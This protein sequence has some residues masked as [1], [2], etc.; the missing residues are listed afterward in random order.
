MVGIPFCLQSCSIWDC[1]LRLLCQDTVHSVNTN[2][3]S[4]KFWS[5][6]LP[7]SCEHCLLNLSFLRFWVG[8]S[9]LCLSKSSVLCFCSFVGWLWFCFFVIPWEILPPV[10]HFLHNLKYLLSFL[11]YSFPVCFPSLSYWK[12][13]TAITSSGAFQGCSW[14]LSY[15][16]KVFFCWLLL[17]TGRDAFLFQNLSSFLL[18]FQ[19]ASAP[20]MLLAVQFFHARYFASFFL[21]HVFLRNTIWSHEI[22]HQS[23]LFSAQGPMA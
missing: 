3:K 13:V 18:Y 11:P 16:L 21:V 22:C 23:V 9:V 19:R 12:L 20:V 15:H 4:G 1:L 10:F 8:S 14:K 7:A 6:H 17:L 5:L 2:I